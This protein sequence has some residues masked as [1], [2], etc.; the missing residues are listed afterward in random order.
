EDD[1]A[2]LGVFPSDHVITDEASYARLL[3]IAF[4]TAETENTIVTVGV[5]PTRPETG[6][7]Y[8]ELGR[9]HGPHVRE[10]KR[11]VEKPDPAQADAY[12]ASGNYAWN[13]GMF[14]AP[15]RR[16]LDEIARHLPTTGAALGQIAAALRAGGRAAAEL[17]AAACYLTLPSISIDY[18]VMEKS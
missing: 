10:V 7:G 9:A 12:L 1:A 6:F 14:F 16:M 13:A 17:T 15:A 3:E 18:G 2:V 11:F 5:M 8:L 4:R